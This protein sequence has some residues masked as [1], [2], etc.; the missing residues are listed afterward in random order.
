[1]QMCMNMNSTIRMLFLCI[2]HCVLHASW[3]LSAQVRAEPQSHPL[4]VSI[5]EEVRASY[6]EFVDGRDIDSITFYGGAAAHRDVI[7]I[8]LLQQALRLGGFKEPLEFRIEQNYF[9][10]LRHITEGTLIS[11]GALVWYSDIL[12]LPELLHISAPIINEG[13]SIVGFY[14]APTNKEA[15]EVKDLKQLRKLRAVSST[16]WYA[17]VATLKKLEI[18]KIYFAADRVQMGRMIKAGR[19]DFT[20]A[21]FQ[22]NEGMKLLLEDMALVPIAGIKASLAGS[23]HWPVSI[24]HPRGAEYYAALQKGIALLKNQGR[25]QQAYQDGGFFYPEVKDWKMIDNT[26]AKPE[27]KTHRTEK[28]AKP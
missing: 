2:C 4:V 3:L 20:L 25:I 1:M 15:L 19:A 14:T 7:D 11:S 5:Y 22:P 13:E 18:E 16:Q 26:Q 6:D 24:K 8:V 17:D 27:Q 12:D 9:S 28:I 10:S 23:R 21:P